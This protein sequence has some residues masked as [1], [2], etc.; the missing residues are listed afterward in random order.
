MTWR[1]VGGATTGLELV[2]FFSTRDAHD[3]Q[4]SPPI[5]SSTPGSTPVAALTRSPPPVCWPCTTGGGFT[6]R[7]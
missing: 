7:N 2:S 4:M 6:L 1:S 5:A 3:A